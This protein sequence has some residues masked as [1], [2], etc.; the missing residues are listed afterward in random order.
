[1]LCT[2][3][4]N[5]LVGWQAKV[6]RNMGYASGIIPYSSQEFCAVGVLGNYSVLLYRVLS[7]GNGCINVI[8]TGDCQLSSDLFRDHNI[9]LLSFSALI[10]AR[11]SDKI[12][13]SSI[14]KTSRKYLK[15]FCTYL[16]SQFCENFRME[17]DN[18]R[19]RDTGEY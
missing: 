6:Q 17:E 13:F 2:Q 11:L 4:D 16:V 19:K 1:M 7:I 10:S 8:P 9:S 3:K 18:V 12:G 5:S 14:Y 15:P